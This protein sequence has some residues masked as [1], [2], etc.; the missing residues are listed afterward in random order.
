MSE[1]LRKMPAPL[2]AEGQHNVLFP[3]S[4]KRDGWSVPG[5]GVWSRVLTGP[6]CYGSQES[7][8]YPVEAV[9]LYFRVRIG[10]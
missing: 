8:L 1:V 4:P 10:T 5:L 7:L 9:S 3:V 6:R 2:L